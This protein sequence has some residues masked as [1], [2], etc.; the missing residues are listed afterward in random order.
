VLLFLNR[1]HRFL[2]L[3][4]VLRLIVINGPEGLAPLLW[5]RYLLSCQV[6]VGVSVSIRVLVFLIGL[7]LPH[8]SVPHGWLIIVLRVVS[9]HAALCR[10]CIELVVGV[11]PSS[12]VVSSHLLVAVSAHTSSHSQLSSSHRPS[13]VIWWLV[14]HAAKFSRAKLTSSVTPTQAS[15]SHS[16][17]ITPSSSVASAIVHVV[18]G[19]AHPLRLLIGVLVLVAES[20]VNACSHS[21]ATVVRVGSLLLVVAGRRTLVLAK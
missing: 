12:V 4:G 8:A 17:S 7:L 9:L 6:A 16:P 15:T 20:L 11:K 21:L 18:H 1:P 13:S 14:A 3:V 5:L 19:V 2:V 10:N